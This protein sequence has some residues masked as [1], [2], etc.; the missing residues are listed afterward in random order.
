MS[1]ASCRTSSTLADICQSIVPSVATSAHSPL[2]GE[3]TALSAWTAA[4]VTV[5]WIR[6]VKLNCRSW[7]CGARG[8]GQ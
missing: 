1:P 8:L 4:S 6:T 5:P 2:R 3:K 7:G